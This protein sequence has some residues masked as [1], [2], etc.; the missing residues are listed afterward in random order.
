MTPAQAAAERVEA[1]LTARDANWRA[2]S[3]SAP[4]VVVTFVGTPPLTASDLRALVVAARGGEREARFT[5][6]AELVVQDVRA[7]RGDHIAGLVE[8]SFR[9]HFELPDDLLPPTHPRGQH[10]LR[11]LGAVV[12]DEPECQHD[13]TL[14]PESDTWVCEMCGAER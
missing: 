4:E 1:F 14:R 8:D 9:E 11:E 13:W 10:R 12:T 2:V 6:A 3:S 7:Q 5:A